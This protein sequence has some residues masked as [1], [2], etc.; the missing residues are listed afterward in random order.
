MHCTHNTCLFRRGNAF[1]RITVSGVC[2]EGM[3]SI[4]LVA[5]TMD[6]KRNTTKPQPRDP[7][8]L[9]ERHYI[10]T[11]ESMKHALY[12]LL[13]LV[14]SSEIPSHTI[15]PPHQSQHQQPSPRSTAWSESL[16][17]RNTLNRL[18]FVIGGLR[19]VSTD[20]KCSVW[21]PVLAP[22]PSA[23]PP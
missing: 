13:G 11:P 8:L 9:I 3:T 23:S 18:T 17:P 10:P 2:S 5:T 6:K 16:G 19:L 21:L 4:S 20:L 22:C 1:Q 7:P 14:G 15:S 12:L